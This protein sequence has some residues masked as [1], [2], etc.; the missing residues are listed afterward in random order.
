MKRKKHFHDKNFNGDETKKKSPYS[1]MDMDFINCK[2]Y[3]QPDNRIDNFVKLVKNRVELMKNKHFQIKNCLSINSKED[4]FKNGCNNDD[5]IYYN[6]NNEENNP[7]ENK[8]Q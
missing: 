1:K 8:K 7:I 4:N 3:K 2:K 5:S 6:S